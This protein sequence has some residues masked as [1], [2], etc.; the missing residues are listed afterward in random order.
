MSKMMTNCATFRFYE[1]LNDF[2]ARGK[3]KATIPVYFGGNPPVK[4]IIESIGVPH[5]EVDLILVNSKSVDFSYHL[6]NGDRVSVYPVFES[7]DISDVTHLRAKPLRRP[8]YILDVHLGKLAKYLRMFGF[9]TLYRNNYHDSQIVSIAGTEK[10]IILTRDIGI[11]KIKEVT[12]GY[13]IRSQN[14]N[15]QL[16]EVIDHFDLYSSIK[17]FHRCMTCNGIIRKV[18]KETIHDNLDEKTKKYYDEF[19]RCESCG[20]IYWKGSHYNRMKRFI[21]DFKTSPK[22]RHGKA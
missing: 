22:Y 9:D 7:L 13:W 18:K 8:K 5:T 17:P 11:L 15:K 14:L 10:R 6:K 19:Y 16:K 2:F 1:E 4:D 12:H 3:R 20:T 21:E